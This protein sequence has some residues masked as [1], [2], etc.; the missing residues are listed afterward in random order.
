[1]QALLIFLAAA[2]LLVVIGFYFPTKT[3]KTP[4]N[5]R[6]IRQSDTSRWIKEINST[7]EK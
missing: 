6:D 2:L 1:M 3:H 7:G 4:Q 5:D